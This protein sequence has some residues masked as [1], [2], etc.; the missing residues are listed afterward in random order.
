MCWNL[1]N[2]HLGQMLLGPKEDEDNSGMAS[3]VSQETS[4]RAELPRQWGRRG[5]AG[6]SGDRGWRQLCDMLA[7]D[8]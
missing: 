5:G 8:S 7:S 2:A 6:G 4:T 3:W 1:W